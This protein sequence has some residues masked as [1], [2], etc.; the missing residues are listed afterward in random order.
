MKTIAKAPTRLTNAEAKKYGYDNLDKM[1]HKAR[2]E[3][4]SQWNENQ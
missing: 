2:E 3:F 1:N 4:N